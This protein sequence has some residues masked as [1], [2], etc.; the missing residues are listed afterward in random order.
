MTLGITPVWMNSILRNA[1]SSRSRLRAVHAECAHNFPGAVRIEA[2]AWLD[3][4]LN[5][6]Q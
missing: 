6:G 5:P 3:A 1:A 4:W 2:Y